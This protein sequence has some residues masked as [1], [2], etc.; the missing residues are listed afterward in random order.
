MRASELLKEDEGSRPYSNIVTALTVLHNRVLD[1]EIPNKLP[2]P[3]ILRYI[4]NTGV[5]S[6]DYQDLLNANDD[7][8]F[9]PAIQK[10]VANIT[11]DLVEFNTDIET[12]VT[13]PE[14][15]KTA[16]EN[17]EEKVSKMADRAL[18]RRQK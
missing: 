16:A 10:L 8:D 18:K 2:T 4:R 6:M 7:E 12:S 9:G 17:P 5:T 3:M 1:K 15:V 13:N 14:E 11:P